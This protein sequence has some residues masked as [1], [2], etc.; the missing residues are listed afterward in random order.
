MPIFWLI[1]L[2]SWTSLEFSLSFQIR[3]QKKE[4][5]MKTTNTPVRSLSL[6]SHSSSICFSIS[7]GPSQGQRKKIVPLSIL[8]ASF[9]C[10]E[11][12]DTFFLWLIFSPLLP[13]TDWKLKNVCS[14]FN[15][16]TDHKRLNCESKLDIQLVFL[17][18][19]NII[20]KKGLKSRCATWSSKNDLRT[21]TQTPRGHLIR[22]L[23]I[24]KKVCRMSRLLPWL[25]AI[26]IH[27][28]S[29]VALIQTI[30]LLNS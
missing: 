10:R 8:F 27:T 30:Y 7:Q 9:V 4:S 18:E 25:L 26:T 3:P 24:S 19:V 15:T 6:T 14:A 1:S 21:H 20:I 11:P 23:W 5:K 29:S 22:C 12:E 28:F 13:L 2:Y 16:S 17:S